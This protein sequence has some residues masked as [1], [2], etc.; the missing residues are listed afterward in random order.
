[1]RHAQ[2]EPFY[3]GLRNTEGGRSSSTL[4]F[5]LR[6][7]VSATSFTVIGWCLRGDSGRLVLQRQEQVQPHVRV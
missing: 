3:V 4:R 1:M 5:N 2:E 6:K 7:A